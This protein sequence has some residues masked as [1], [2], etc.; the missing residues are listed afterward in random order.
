[1]AILL[2][3]AAA[4]SL[5]IDVKQSGEAVAH[6]GEF[7]FTLAA[8]GP[9]GQPFP[10]AIIRARLWHV[11]EYSLFTTDVPYVEN[12]QVFDVQGSPEDGILHVAA[13]APIPGK[14]VLEA[15]ATDPAG[16][17]E[18]AD[19]MEEY[20]VPQIPEKTIRGAL[21]LFFFLAAGF[22]GGYF[23]LRDGRHG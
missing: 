4:A 23:F 1:M 16:K 15:R 9:G 7:N 18:D 13:M 14:Y 5:S 10:G 3:A 12:A 19:V 22:A 6:E 21:L 2:A 8:K 17:L 20:A 11:S